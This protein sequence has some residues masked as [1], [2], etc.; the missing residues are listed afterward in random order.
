MACTNCGNGGDVQGYTVRFT[1]GSAEPTEMD[2]VL[3][4]ACAEEFSE[5]PGIELR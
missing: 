2:L 5:E 4:P 3:C 1:Q